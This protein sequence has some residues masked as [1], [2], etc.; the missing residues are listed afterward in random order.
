MCGLSH[1]SRKKK[2]HQLQ[3]TESAGLCRLMA[4]HRKI[5]SLTYKLNASPNHVARSSQLRRAC[6]SV[7]RNPMSSVHSLCLRLKGTIRT[8]TSQFL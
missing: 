8:T 4:G 3:L 1:T 5:Y 7:Q 6:A 2:T